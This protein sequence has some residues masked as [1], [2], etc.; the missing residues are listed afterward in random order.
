MA[1]PTSSDVPLEDNTT[2]V[3][4]TDDP[5]TA[6]ADASQPKKK[7]YQ[8]LSLPTF[9]EMMMQDMMNNC[10]IKS[11][12]SGVMGGGMGIAFGLFTSS[13]ENASGGGIDGSLAA[14]ENRPTRVVMKEMALNMKT[15]SLSYAKGFA[16]MGFLYSG[17]ECL[18]E[19]HRAKHDK[20]N[21]V[22]AG[23]ITGGI[24]AHSGGPQAM[25]IGCASFAAFS[26]AIEH[27]LESD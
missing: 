15:K 5:S 14:Q 12:M 22:Y 27:F 17:I 1:E 8:Q 9:D 11:V 13:M 21:P 23:C 4:V 26:A 16:A 7:K 18:V 25:A 2:P 24:L 20:L 3:A 6:E 19:K 10:F